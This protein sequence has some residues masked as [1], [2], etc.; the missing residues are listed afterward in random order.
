MFSL[1]VR[2]RMRLGLLAI[3]LILLPAAAS[4]SMEAP[5]HALPLLYEERV[6][7]DAWRA[8]V[9]STDG[10]PVEFGIEHAFQPDIGFIGFRL[11]AAD[12]T[13]HGGLEHGFM[14]GNTVSLWLHTEP[15]GRVLFDETA[16]SG[17]GNVPPIRIVLN[18]EGT[19]PFVGTF[20]VLLTA[21]G[22]GTS[23]F[24]ISGEGVT[25][26]NQT[27]GSK[28]IDIR[29]KHMEGSFNAHVEAQKAISVSVDAT[30]SFE[31]EHGLF[32]WA[33]DW[34]RLVGNLTLRR[35]A[36]GFVQTCY[37][38]FPSRDE[39]HGPGKYTLMRNAVAGPN[40]P[41]FP[42]LFAYDAF[43]PEA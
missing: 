37:C 43:L 17:G 12:G 34:S 8:F 32:G 6:T 1:D 11:F 39:P 20:K 35:E 15:T 3:L 31:V 16:A 14:K 10:R 38:N 40:F 7:G 33:A 23:V 25:L 5:E 13:P 22:A 28:V 18:E 24:R 9:F 27:S 4:G 21:H 19:K 42:I 29:A 30:S 36:D 26:G 41:G 2:F